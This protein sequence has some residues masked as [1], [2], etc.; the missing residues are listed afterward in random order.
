[1]YCNV[2]MQRAASASQYISVQLACCATQLAVV[3][4]AKGS[5]PA[6]AVAAAAG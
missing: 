5:E 2:L 6:V 1:M 4:L 3:A